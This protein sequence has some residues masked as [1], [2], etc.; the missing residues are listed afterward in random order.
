[1]NWCLKG[2]KAHEKVYNR[3]RNTHPFYEKFSLHFTGFQTI[4][5]SDITVSAKCSKKLFS[6]LL[7]WK[8]KDVDRYEIS[9]SHLSTIVTTNSFLFQRWL[10]SILT[11]QP[12]CV[13][14]NT[15][16]DTSGT[17]NVHP[18]GTLS[19]H[20]FN[21]IM[22]RVT[23]ALALS[24]VFAIFYLGIK[25]L[26]Y[27]PYFKKIY[28]ISYYMD[29]PRLMK[30]P[31]VFTK[32]SYTTGASVADFWP[33]RSNWIPPSFCRVLV[34]PVML[35]IMFVFSSI[36]MIMSSDL[37]ISG[38]PFSMFKFLYSIYF[39]FRKFFNYVLFNAKTDI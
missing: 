20:R 15:A 1:M 31:W 34:T 11:K 21:F 17:G 6:K 19:S 36:L 38:C 9:T 28:I 3:K 26:A 35:C 13:V 32:M 7:L 5:A 29:L 33:F 30:Y 16:C 2:Q 25:K 18:S 27:I 10:T 14:N 22:I 23:L 37:K 24:F 12:L 39:F 8:W 4:Q